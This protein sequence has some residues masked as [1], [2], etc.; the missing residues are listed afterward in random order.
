[1]KRPETSGGPAASDRWGRVKAVF[2]EALDRSEAERS[3][4]LTSACAGDE[5]LKRE[6]ESLLASDREAG[7]FGE[8]P[9]ADLLEAMADPVPPA[10]HLAPGSRLGV[11]EIT[12][13]IGAGGMGEIY[14][15]RDTRLG[16]EVALKTVGAAVTDADAK[17]RLLKEARHASI[18]NHPNICTIHE[19][20]DEDARPYIVMEYVDG[21]S[22]RQIREERPPGARQAITY[23]IQI[24]D[25]L[26][27]AHRRG[28][29]HRDLKSSNIVVDSEGRAIVLDFGLARRL[30]DVTGAGSGDSSITTQHAIAGTLGYMAPEVLLGGR[31]DARSD[32]WALGVLLHEMTGGELPFDGR[33]SFET[34]SAII[35]EP[36]RPLPRGV[37]LALR[38]VIER[39][40]A[41]DPAARYQRA[42]DVRDALTAISRRRGWTVVGRLLM[43]RRRRI[44]QVAAAAVLVAAAIVLA[45]DRLRQVIGRAGLPTVRTMAVLPLENAT[46]NPEDQYFADGMTDAIIAQV[47]S[48]G[49]L[50]VISRTSSQRMAAAGKQ[51][52]EIGGALGAEAVVQGAFHRAGDRVRMDVRLV[53]ARTGHVLWSD[54]YER[55]VRD[56]LVL[57]A[58]VVRA[59]A[60]SIHGTLHPEARDRLAMVR[61]VNP[62]AYEEFLRG[63]FQWNRRTQASLQLAVGHFTRAL[64]LDPTYAPAYAALADCY[65]QFGTVMVGTGSP[66]TY[67]PR[68]AAEAI[69]ALQIDPSSAEAHA[70]LGYVHHYNWKWDEAEREFRRAIDLNPSYALARLWY[71]N[72]LMSRR[73]LDEAL[74]EVYVARDLDPFSLI[75]NTNVGWVLLFARRDEEAIDHLTRTLELDPDY[76]QALSRLANALVTAGRFDAALA[77]ANR[78]V[79]LTNR[80]PTSLSLV[81]ELHAKAGRR[82]E[83]QE[84]LGEV[85]RIAQH[86]YVPPGAIAGVYIRLGELDAAFKWIE[87]AYE[88]RSNYIAY[89]AVEPGHE[90]L[91]ADPRFKSLL[92]RAGL[93]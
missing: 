11:Y 83:A 64:E 9:A 48:L 76:Q 85:L 14:R 3:A 43:P 10:V 88:E 41:K 25:A 13:F 66:Q 72:L 57:Q 82:R 8:T 77:H 79:Q 39:C 6:V 35:S 50:R 45:G 34:S 63:R 38:L 16:R 31:A 58:E 90:P 59:L 29:V 15:A 67:R 52:A 80:S 93:Q 37:P 20:G 19:I 61:T 2:L 36:P 21:R 54:T 70:A 26:A 17:H 32:V 74:R 22:L 46:G 5:L 60:I 81:A 49:T 4:F 53:E 71:A 86:Q 87:K 33:T 92:Q 12:S 55:A 68:A 24:A 69:K 56:V 51:V 18:L 40:L 65:N 1:M 28:I 89:L 75:T 47:G 78:L 30:P 73:R 7:D 42:D 44:A 27:H 91:R 23:G 84:L 62:Q